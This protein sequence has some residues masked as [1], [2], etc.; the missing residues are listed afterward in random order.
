MN[1]PISKT[2]LV[3][4]LTFSSLTLTA[5]AKSDSTNQIRKV[6]ILMNNGEEFTGNLMENSNDSVIVQSTNGRYYLASTNIKSIRYLT[7]EKK[8]EFETPNA[9]RYF[10]GPSAIPLKKRSGYYQNVMVTTNFINYGATKNFSIGGGFEF[11]SLMMGSP[12]WFLTPKV[13]FSITEKIHIGGG[14]II[15]F[16][17]EGTASLGYG[18][19]TLGD[20]ETNFTLGAGHGIYNSEIAERPAVMFAGTHRVG[21]NVALL[22]ENYVIPNGGS[23]YLGI[24]GIRILSKKNTFDIG[25]I[26]IPAIAEDVLALPYVGYVRAF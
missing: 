14:V 25:A 22:S 20:S 24:H 12:I 15:G 18:A 9:T 10:F 17:T 13:G 16:S 21:N 3:L 1:T 2:I 4:L 23:D 19:F 26:V 5:Q 8:F 11:I 6:S 7:N